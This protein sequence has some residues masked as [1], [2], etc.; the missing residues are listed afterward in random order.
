M[1]CTLRVTAP[2]PDLAH[3]WV[4]RQ[5]F[6]VG[7]PIEFDA[8]SDRI[9]ALEYALGA[10]AGEVVNGLRVFASRRRIDIDHIEA[11][12][13]AELA[14]EGVYLEVVG[15]TGQPR[16]VRVHLKVFAAS[17]DEPELRRLWSELPDK[18]PLVCTMRSAFSI[19]L[20]LVTTS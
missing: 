8:E 7:R 19:D 18:L 16:I 20:E 9:A 1:L 13:T 3:V 2:A 6:A 5:Q 11:V 4:R 17:P 10:V 12:V 14:C 15:E